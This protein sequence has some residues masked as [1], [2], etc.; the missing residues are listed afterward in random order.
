MP[1]QLP[2]RVSLWRP[3]PND[4]EAKK[5]RLE[6]EPES[7]SRK[8][9]AVHGR[10]VHVGKIKCRDQHRA[11]VARC[12]RRVHV[13]K[14]KHR[15]QHRAEQARFAQHVQLRVRVSLFCFEFPLGRLRRQSKCAHRMHVGKI[16]YRDQHRAEQARFAQH[17][18]LRVHVSLFCFEFS[19][20]RLRCLGALSQR[21][22]E[23]KKRDLRE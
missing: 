3:A 21:E 9:G 7:C 1:I 23:A 22:L 4:F 20:G 11:E 15:D 8:Q 16:K 6:G 17:M 14:T 12:A 2:V 10:R 18:Q 13:G 19:L 5:G